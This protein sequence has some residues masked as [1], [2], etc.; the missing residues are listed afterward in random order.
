MRN[1]ALVGSI[2]AVALLVACATQDEGGVS[3]AADTTRT[4]PTMG[5]GGPTRGGQTTPPVVTTN[6]DGGAAPGCYAGQGACEPTNATSCGKG[7]TCDLNGGTGM[8]QCFPPPNDALLGEPC[9]NGAGPFCAQG[10]A[11]NG[12][13]CSAYCCDDSICAAG[14]TCQETGTV[15]SVTIKVCQ[16][17]AVAPPR[18]TGTP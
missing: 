2:G 18:L 15:G 9:D 5:G 10:L 14:E 4:T 1:V 16:T 7:E 13:F 6:A 11:C 8:F 12:G 17:A 3:S